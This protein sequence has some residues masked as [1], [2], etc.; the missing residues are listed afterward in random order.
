M[1]DQVSRMACEGLSASLMR[2][3][4]NFLG[5]VSRAASGLEDEGDKVDVWISVKFD[6]FSSLANVTWAGAGC[7]SESWAA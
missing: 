5:V 7:R 4:M 6:L 2:L 1:A 3:L